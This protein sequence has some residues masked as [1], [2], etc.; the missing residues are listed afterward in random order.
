MTTQEATYFLLNKL[1]ATYSE[2]EATQITDWVME[3]LT[4]SKKAERMIYKNSKITKKEETRL[5][6]IAHRL[7]KNEPVQYVLNEAWFC[8][9]KF[10]VDENV[11]I[12]RP[13]TEELV[14]W[15]VSS[16]LAP[17]SYRDA[18]RQPQR[19]DDTIKILD[20]GTGS[21]CIAISLK[22][23][24][25]EAEV[26]ACD[27][28][29]GA[30]N[31][32]RKNSDLLGLDIECVQLDFL[33]EGE[34]NR[35]GAFDIIVSNPPYVPER[36]K[37][38]MQANVLEY[39]PHLALFVPDNKPLI[40]YKAIATF[41]KLHLKKGGMIFTELHEITGRDAEKLFKSEG[42]NTELKKDMQNKERILKSILSR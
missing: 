29:E 26:L 13:E 2:S 11:L 38:Q 4:G 24:L 27:V 8:G 41:G 40:F 33:N 23:K 18:S 7:M 20:I 1:K 22:R 5:Q 17:D 25:K 14:E 3:H 35:L 42:Y 19:T 12:P 21:G 39:E 30:L 36:D 16:Q 34:R 10:Y 9:M 28:S 31:V 6:E 15:I 32:A 37:G